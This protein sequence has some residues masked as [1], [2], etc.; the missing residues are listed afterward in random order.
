MH[1]ILLSEIACNL[2]MQKLLTC[3]NCEITKQAKMSHYKSCL[4]IQIFKQVHAFW[5]I[6]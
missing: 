4:L 1:K 2:N 3:Q 5:S 6:S